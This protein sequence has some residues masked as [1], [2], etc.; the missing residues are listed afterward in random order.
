MRGLIA[1]SS[2]NR[3]FKLSETFMSEILDFTISAK[4]NAT[5]LQPKPLKVKLK[6]L[7][8]PAAFTFRKKQKRT[9]EVGL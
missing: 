9:Q 3:D 6:Q 1:H 5:S 4:P 2:F 7:G 8:T